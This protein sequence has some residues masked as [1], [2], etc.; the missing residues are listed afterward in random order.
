M[1]RVITPQG[2]LVMIAPLAT[3]IRVFKLHQLTVDRIE[4]ETQDGRACALSFEREILIEPTV[5]V[6]KDYLYECSERRIDEFM[7]ELDES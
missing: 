5:F 2:N 1:Y 6:F 3:L 7:Q 4:R